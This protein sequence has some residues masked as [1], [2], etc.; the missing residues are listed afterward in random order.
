[1]RRKL[2]KQ[3]GELSAILCILTLVFSVFPSP[4]QIKAA[5]NLG[6]G[7][8]YK[9]TQIEPP[10][11]SYCWDVGGIFVNAKGKIRIHSRRWEQTV[12]GVSGKKGKEVSDP[13]V[14]AAYNAWDYVKDKERNTEFCYNTINKKGTAGY[15]T[16]R[17]IIFKYNKKGKILKRFYVKKESGGEFLD[18][19][20]LKWVSGD[21]VAL[22]VS[23]AGYN[24]EIRRYN[25]RIIL[26]DM[27][28]RKIIKK[29]STK[30]TTLCGTDGKHI[31][32]MSGSAAQ[33]TEKIVK[34]KASSGKEVSS[35]STQTIR[36]LAEDGTEKG[37]S[38]DS[39]KDDSFDTCYSGGKL[40]LRY[41]TGIYTWNEKKKRFDTVLDGID[42]ENYTFVPLY[43]ANCSTVFEVTEKGKKIY[44][45]GSSDLYMYS[46]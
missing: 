43:G 11:G 46:L 35:I 21:R 39:R 24:S 5:G 41:C 26:V 19:C 34:L 18:V 1:M 12:Y 16:N 30:Y 9:E 17:K 33:K 45:A 3:M 8:P 28:K 7:K 40:Y 25:A 2:R 22:Q 13:M 32:V 44:V 42:S 38:E 10:K 14:K 4:V 20:G 31:Y 36:A 15:F 29:Y 27:G 37:G 6:K 23:Y